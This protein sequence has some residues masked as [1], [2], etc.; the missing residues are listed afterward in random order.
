MTM[1]RNLIIYVPGNRNHGYCRL[2]GN[3]NYVISTEINND[4]KD[5]LH[6]IPSTSM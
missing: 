5:I 4:S 6:K 2:H 1:N 3:Q